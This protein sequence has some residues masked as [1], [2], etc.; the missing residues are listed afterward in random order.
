MKNLVRIKTFFL[1]SISLHKFLLNPVHLKQIICG[2]GDLNSRTPMRMDS[3]STAYNQHSMK[4][5]P[6]FDHTWQFPHV[7]DNLNSD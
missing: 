5:N 7:S 2:K 3:K 1:I 4:S 6:T